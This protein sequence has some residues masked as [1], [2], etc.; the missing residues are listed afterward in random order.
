MAEQDENPYAKFTGFRYLMDAK[1]QRQYAVEFVNG[2]A[3]QPLRIFNPDKPNDTLAPGETVFAIDDEQELGLE[4]GSSFINAIVYKITANGSDNEQPPSVNYFSVAYDA[5]SKYDTGTTTQFVFKLAPEAKEAALAGVPLRFDI[6][7][8]N[9][10]PALPPHHAGG[11]ARLARAEIAKTVAPRPKP[12]FKKRGAPK[13]VQFKVSD[14]AILKALEEY[15]EN[16]TEKAQAGRLDPIVGRDKETTQALKVLTRRNQGSLCF[17]GEPGVGK[18]AMF[19]AVAQHLVAHRDDMP[20]SLKDAVVIKLD[21]QKANA[22]SMYRGDFEKKVKPIIDGLME[23]EGW[24]RFRDGKERKVIL[25]MDELHSQMTAGQAEGGTNVAQLMK[26]FLVADGISAMATTTNEEYRK[27][28]EKDTAFASRFEQLPLTQ[29]NADETLFILKSLW[30]LIRN[31]NCLTEDT[32][33]EGQAKFEELLRYIVTMTNRYAPQE[34]QPRKA[35][36]ALNMAAASAEFEHHEMITKDDII[37]AVSQMS[38]L[39]AE[40]L[41]QS[42]AQRFIDLKTELPKEVM[43]QPGIAKIPR[44]LIGAR[45]GLAKPEQP[46]GCFVLQ[47]PTGTGKTETC[48]VL[49]RKLFGS[50]DAIVRLNMGEY[51]EKHTVARLI[52]AP[53]GYLGHDSTEPALTEKIRQKPFSILLLDEIEKAHPDVFNTL[54][55]ILEHGKMTD[56]QGKTVLFNNVI[57]VMTTNVGA[58]KVQRLI[59]SNGST[60]RMGFGAGEEMPPEELRKKM[61]EIYDASAKRENGGPFKP[62]MINRINALGGFITF[63]PLEED[64]IAKIADREIS[65]TSD[66]LSAPEGSNIPGATLEVSDDIKKQLCKDGYNPAMGARP[67]QTMVREKIVNPVSEWVL[68]HGD[69]VRAYIAENGPAKIVIDKLE[70]DEEGGPVVNPRLVAKAAAAAV[71]ANDNAPVEQKKPARKKAGPQP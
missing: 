63:G 30:P 65:Q 52:G 71:S 64:V 58:E 16:Y 57:I 8:N 23:R 60:S 17:T 35:V 19:K 28:V 26:D 45:A 33:P 3:K 22:G 24:V 34:A 5:V 46:W 43:G 25:A 53:P 39:P 38:K 2:E 40:F 21:L 37:D 70:F 12:A 54:L 42:D 4:N 29:P 7:S 59:E 10:S 15:G 14:D 55:P 18:S 67:L 20:E 11:K 36:K 56:N 62:E 68:L 31:H 47:G 44:G 48:K 50:E 51:S 66:R 27:Y 9:P 1:T 41:T 69:E 13:G 61:A 49:A 6:A 32:S